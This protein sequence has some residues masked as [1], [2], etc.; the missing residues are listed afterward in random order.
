MEGRNGDKPIVHNPSAGTS[1]S[2][3][4]VD[5][6]VEYTTLNM[7]KHGKNRAWPLNEVRERARVVR[8]IRMLRG[9][10]H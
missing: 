8:E 10:A 3:S 6:V 7:A 2:A 1:F 9:D 5:H 4:N